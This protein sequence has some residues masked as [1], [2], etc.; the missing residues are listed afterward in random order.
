MENPTATIRFYK[1]TDKT[2]IQPTLINL[3][4]YSQHNN[5]EHSQTT[6]KGSKISLP[7]NMKMK[8]EIL[9]DIQKMSQ[10]M[11]NDI[12]IRNLTEHST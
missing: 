8:E 1:E 5:I 9:Q 4:F 10:I 11:D 12:I 2:G 6:E 3:I 7:R